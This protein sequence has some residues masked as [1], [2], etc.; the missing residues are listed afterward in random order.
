MFGS[1]GGRKRPLINVSIAITKNKGY[2]YEHIETM[3]SA[4]AVATLV[5]SGFH[6]H[7]ILRACRE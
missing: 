6:E 7:A 5:E 1:P 4:P 2:W 3:P